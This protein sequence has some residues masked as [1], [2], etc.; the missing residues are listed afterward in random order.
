MNTF[1][2]LGLQENIL[3]A[4]K[5]LGFETPMPVQEAVIPR[6]IENNT[7]IVA[8]AQTGTGKTAAFG[9]PLLQLIDPANKKTQAL[10]LSPT[11]ELC[12]QIAS[13]LNSYSKY[14][15]NIKV[16]AIYG[17][18][19]IEAQAKQLKAGTQI[20]AATPGRMLDMIMRKYADLSEVQFLVLDEADE[21]LDMGFEEDVQSI[22]ESTP[23]DRHTFLFS[24]TM[25]TDVEK[26]SRRYMKNPETLSMGQRNIGAA[27]VKH[28]YYLTHARDRYTVLKRVADFH[29]DMYAIVFC[30]TRQETQEIS[31]S[32]IRDGYSADALHGDLSQSQRDHV[33]KKFREKH[34]NM[35]VATDVAARGIDV[36]D[37]THVINY[38]LPDDTDNYIHRSGRTGRAGKDGISISIINMKEKGRIKMLER[39]IGKPFSAG[40]IPSGRQVCEKQLYHLI[41]RM[42]NVNVIEDEINDFL[43]VIFKKLEWMSKEEIIKRFVSVEFNSFLEY[44]RDAKDLNVDESRERSDRS[45]G[46]A[47]TRL[48]MS[49]GRKDG[50]TV[51]K[52][53]G[54]VNEY[55]QSR[56]LKVGRIELG[57]TFTFIEVDTKYLPLFMASFKDQTMNERPIKVDVAEDQTSSERPGRSSYGGGRG[58]DRGGDRGGY[59]GSGRSG[60]GD[61]SYGGG[62]RGGSGGGGYRKSY[63]SSSDR[64]AYK[65]G[66]DRRSDSSRSAARP[67]SDRGGSRP[68]GG[69]PWYKE[70]AGRPG[71][72]KK[73]F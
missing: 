32:L 15:P 39:Q 31:D 71:K 30:R 18:A 12:M 48:F 57:D 50:L 60:S 21:M 51:P 37:L 41:D 63:G 45:E 61:R 17:G 22:I 40:K 73:R 65:G 35:L 66:G 7:D 59:R 72:K 53:L 24:A 47:F 64:P 6:I 69:E 42:E 29:P 43:P 58:G 25:P 33:M 8:L 26:I 9:L 4:I 19:S 56:D 5:E 49:I 38:Q 54:M 44:Y 62:D 46:G 55:T 13:D 34:L 70:Q 23:K 16:T 52:L 14:M 10:I 67:D 2:Q 20:I 3:K 68:S 27:N 28:I 11:R 1:D 36:S